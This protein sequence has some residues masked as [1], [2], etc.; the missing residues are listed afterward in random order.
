LDGKTTQCL[1]AAAVGFARDGGLAEFLTWPADHIV[2][3]PDSISSAAAALVEPASVAAHAIRSGVVNSTDNIAVIGAGTVG[4]LACQI[5]K[6]IGSKVD[7]FDIRQE[8][9]DLLNALGGISTYKIPGPEYEVAIQNSSE[10]NGYDVVVDAAGHRS[11][12]NEA[13]KL[14][15]HGGKIVLVAI[16]TEVSQIDFNALVSTEK[17]LIGSLA[18]EQKDVEYVVSLL[19]SGRLETEML[20]SDVIS[21]EEVLSIGFQRMMSESKDVFRILVNPHN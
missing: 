11:T 4:N 10:G 5:A 2:E 21:L 12:P 19:S 17:Q 15:R 6:A 18:Y 7:A 3:L 20:I 14:A 8:P 13:A 9:L 1:G 16:Y